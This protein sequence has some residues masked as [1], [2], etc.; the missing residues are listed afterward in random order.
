MSKFEPAVYCRSKREHYIKSNLAA[1]PTYVMK[2]NKSYVILYYVS[3][4]RA[5]HV[6]DKKY[7]HYLKYI[8]RAPVE[9]FNKGL[10]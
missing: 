8:C 3:E 6:Y 9:Q 2:G 4:P 5:F 1:H 10:S 7:K